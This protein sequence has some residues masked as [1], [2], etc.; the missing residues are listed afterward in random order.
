MHAVNHSAGACRV[1]MTMRPYRAVLPGIAIVLLVWGTFVRGWGLWQRPFW[2]DEAWVANAVTGQTCDE[3]LRQTELPMPPLFAIS[4]RLLGRAIPPPE[5]GLRLIPLACGI[6]C[7]PL[8]YLVTRSLR[9]PRSIALVGMSLCASSLM[10]VR[11]S[12]ELKQYEIEAFCSLLLAWLVFRMRFGRQWTSTVGS[13]LVVLVCL[14]GPWFGYGVVFPATA[15]MMAL[16]LA[17]ITSR[18]PRGL[19]YAGLAGLAA[20]ALSVA[21]VLYVA[22]SAQSRQPALVA[23][24]SNWFIDPANLHDWLRAGYYAAGSASTVFFPAQ[25]VETRDV[26]EQALV[27]GMLAAVVWLLALIGLWRWPG[28][29]R[30]EMICWVVGPWLL[31][32]TAALARRYPFAQPRMMVFA[33]AP[34][35]LVVAAGLVRFIRGCATVF[36]GRGGPGVVAAGVITLL[37]VTYMVNVPLR[38]QHTMLLDCPALLAVLDHE[39]RPGELVVVTHMAGP[40]VQ[41]YVD[42]SRYPLVY[43]PNQAGSL[44]M[45][46]VDGQAFAADVLDRAGI[47]WWI[48][49]LSEWA[50]TD[51]ATLGQAAQRR[52]YK[53]RIFVGEQSRVNGVPRLICL[54]KEVLR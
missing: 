8:S 1:P 37:P 50:D 35:V 23:F 21:G 19:L 52:G 3:L 34:L 54:T 40:C 45:P 29:G 32:L 17:G 43:M 6:A 25:W 10:L 28:R 14:F 18:A 26:N 47:R 4:V 15:L 46:G 53:V 11:W 27:Y 38:Q 36:L 39:Y 31:L 30:R 16:I 24:T 48:V 13:T 49:T 44:R 12:R 2:V 42:E 20:L 7:L 41:F 33:A 9:V 5:F 22:A 51:L